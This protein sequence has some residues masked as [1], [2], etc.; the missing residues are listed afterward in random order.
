[1][2]FNANSK[3]E[4]LLAIPSTD[5]FKLAISSSNCAS[6]SFRVMREAEREE[7]ARRSMAI[8]IED[9]VPFDTP[10]GNSPRQQPEAQRERRREWRK[11]E[12]RASE[13][14][15]LGPFGSAAHSCCIQGVQNRPLQKD[16]PEYLEKFLDFRKGNLVHL[17]PGSSYVLCKRNRMHINRE[18]S[19]GG[20]KEDRKR[21]RR[22]RSVGLQLGLVVV[23]RLS[24][25][26]EGGRERH[27]ARRRFINMAI[28]NCGSS[29]SLNTACVQIFRLE[30]M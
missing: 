30:S 13:S 4:V 29:S 1:M 14:V 23:L 12:R 9:A 5:I 17:K 22:S 24:L 7:S 8:E 3:P 19:S 10:P 27:H 20:R 18:M 16:I 28:F 2:K 15:A 25:G 21:G 6:L 11:S 26:R